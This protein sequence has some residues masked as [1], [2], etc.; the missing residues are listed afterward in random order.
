[1]FSTASVWDRRELIGE[2]VSDSVYNLTIGAVLCWG[3]GVN[4]VM[5]KSIP[6]QAILGINQWVFLGLYIVSVMIGT[7]IYT[8]SDNPSIS[9]VGYNF[10]VVPL[11]L[12]LV[13]TLHFYDADVIAQAFLTTAVI[14]GS[15]MLVASLHSAFF[16]SLGRGLTVA[17][18]VAFLVEIGMSFITGSVPPVFDWIFVLIFSGYI[19]Y[20]WARAQA[21]PKTLDNAVDCAASLYV[22]IVLFFMH[23]LSL[24]SGGSRD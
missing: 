17:L 14:T 6:A 5:I 20:D 7:S 10:L 11:G 12:V 3:F 22:D 16:L 24:L 21:L 18:V 13:R 15:M 23:L 9:F 4:Y 19:G 8:K 1:M 2:Q